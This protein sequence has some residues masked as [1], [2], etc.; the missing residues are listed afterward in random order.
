VL[1]DAGYATCSAFTGEDALRHAR[2]VRPAA[3]VL[4]VCLPMI[5]G[6]E[7]CRALRCS[8]GDRLPILF[9]SGMRTESFDRVAGLLIG[10]DDYLVKPF[11]PDELVARVGAL[12]RRSGAH[13]DT[14]RTDLTAR[15]HEV[16]PCWPTGSSTTR[17]PSA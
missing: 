11:A 13:P 6:Y 2:R 1:G 14:R 3:V 16:R 15:E 4:D 7:V 17:S 9:I 5:F 12:L 10:G 8:Y